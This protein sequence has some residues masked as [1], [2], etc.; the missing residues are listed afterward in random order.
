MTTGKDA[1]NYTLEK[2]WGKLPVWWQYHSCT[3]VAVDSQD[4]VYVLDRGV[5]PV[6]VFDRD[7][8]FLSAWGEGLF[9]FAHSIYI[10][11]KD[12]VWTSDC[13]TQLVMKFTLSGELIQTIGTKDV[14]GT[15]YYGEPFNMP[16][17]VAVAPSGSIFV[18]DGYGNYMVQKF[19]PNGEHIKSWGGPGTAPGKFA[20]VH[21]VDV[22]RDGKVYVCDRENGRIQVFDEDGAFLSEWTGLYMPA[23]ISI[24]KDLAY[25]IE[26]G[27]TPTSGRLSV[28][29]L[30]GKLIARW[31]DDE[32]PG[33]VHPGI[34]H[35]LAVDS[36]GDL[37]VAELN[38]NLYDK[39]VGIW[40]NYPS[41][42]PEGRPRIGKFNHVK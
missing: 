7:G 34:A 9:R 2:G 25:V 28:Y 4:R 39:F 10:D 31:A 24:K 15:T 3:D 35:G 18:A 20:L 5:H 30:D 22:D 37:Y 8:N 40:T 42:R 17:G 23:K 33:V 1:F 14:P 32:G 27:E 29:S 16:T 12:F 6:L 41:H 36:R 13:Y 38:P 19:S 11:S 21:Y 26:Q